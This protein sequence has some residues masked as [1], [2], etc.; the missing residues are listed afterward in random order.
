MASSVIDSHW[1]EYGPFA[2]WLV[3]YL[4]PK[5]I[6]EL[7]TYKGFSASCFAEPNIGD[8][9]TV[10]CNDVG[11]KENLAKY[12]NVRVIIDTFQRVARTWDKQ[13]DILHLDGDHN[14]DATVSDF[15]KF[16]PFLNEKHVVLVHDVLNYSDA[17]LGPQQFMMY[18]QSDSIHKLILPGKC[19]LGIITPNIGI[20]TAIK[21]KYKTLTP[22]DVKVAWEGMAFVYQQW[23][24]EGLKIL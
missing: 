4:Q 10:D 13:I 18:L 22:E 17:G 11:Q 8:V 23:V 6:L 5:A 3:G 21:Q 19:G 15:M 12:K 2:K 7:G 1:N 14:F 20:A 9:Y 16:T 24:K